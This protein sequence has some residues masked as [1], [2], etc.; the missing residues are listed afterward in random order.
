MMFTCIFSLL[1]IPC[2]PRPRDYKV[3]GRPLERHLS[4]R[5]VTSNWS[6]LT[7]T[8]S[9]VRKCYVLSDKRM[10]EFHWILKKWKTHCSKG[11]LEGEEGVHLLMKALNKSERCTGCRIWS[12]T[13]ISIQARHQ[14]AC[15]LGRVS[16]HA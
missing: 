6:F 2:L 8:A 13:W 3:R 9:V 11:C 15:E 4:C 7:D 16:Y 14:I 1:L 5:E 10:H 12:Q